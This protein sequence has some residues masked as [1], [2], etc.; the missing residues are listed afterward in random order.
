MRY[1]LKSILS[2]VFLITL[3]NSFVF[4]QG[5]Y[6]SV[7]QANLNVTLQ[8]GKIPYKNDNKTTDVTGFLTFTKSIPDSL[9]CNVSAIFIH[10]SSTGTETTISDSIRVNNSEFRTSI[11]V[12]KNFTFKLQPNKKAGQVILRFKYYKK[13][14]PNTSN[15]WSAMESGKTWQTVEIDTVPPTL[16]DGPSQICDEGNYTIT[17]PYT[18][19]LEN[20][21]GIAT[22]TPLGNN[23]WKVTRIGTASGLIKLRSTFNGKTYDKNIVIGTPAPTISGTSQINTVGE[24]GY[25]VSRNLPG[26]TIEYNL[27]LGGDVEL[28][29][30]SDTQFTIKVV[31][32]NTS[33]STMAVKVRA[34]ETNS[35]GTSSYTIKNITLN[36]NM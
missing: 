35:C 24:Y 22:L 19:T 12:P 16:F 30:V 5:G 34:R 13:N 9:E 8:D 36:G 17:N 29:P 11:S 33:G 3:C 14:Y 7:Y 18:I 2:I 21:A 31:N 15:G 23:Q 10:R 20:A 27:M 4:A 1:L 25:I 26:S 32:P 6:I 28:I